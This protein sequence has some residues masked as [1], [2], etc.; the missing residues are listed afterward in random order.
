MN[1]NSKNKIKNIQDKFQYHYIFFEISLILKMINNKI[2]YFKIINMS[3]VIYYNN[4]SWI[5]IWITNQKK[6]M[7]INSLN[8]S[9]IYD[10]WMIFHIINHW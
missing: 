1:W 7:H 5:E 6:I 4:K 2:I 10:S 3:K 8:N 9:I